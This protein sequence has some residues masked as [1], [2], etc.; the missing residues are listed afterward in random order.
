M[1]GVILDIFTTRRSYANAVLEVVILS[2][3]PSVCHTR[4]LGRWACFKEELEDRISQ[5]VPKTKNFTTFKKDAW[6]RP[7][8]SSLLQKISKKN[9]LW[10][11]YILCH[12]V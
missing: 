11:R 7:L 8:K 3:R 4:A 5:F 9:R 2:V 1:K 6:K 12:G 10:T